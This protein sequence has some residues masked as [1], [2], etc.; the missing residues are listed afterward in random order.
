MFCDLL[1]ASLSALFGVCVFGCV[2]LRLCLC[3]IEKMPLFRIN[4]FTDI[5]SLRFNMQ[6]QYHLQN[7][8]LSH[9]H[10]EVNF[11]FLGI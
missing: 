5:S 4:W 2:R 6:F 8:K 9:R 10:P 1:Y 3:T 7:I 11:E